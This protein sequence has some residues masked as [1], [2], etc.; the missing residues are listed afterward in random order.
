MP[1]ELETLPGHLVNIGQ[2]LLL[3]AGSKITHIQNIFANYPLDLLFEFR[4]MGVLAGRVWSQEV[5]HHQ[6]IQW[7]WR[8]GSR[9]AYDNGAFSIAR[10]DI[11]EPVFFDRKRVGDGIAVV[12]MIRTV[13]KPVNS[14]PSRTLGGHHHRP[15]RYC[16]GRIA[17]AKRS[18]QPTLADRLQVWQIIKPAIEDQLRCCAVQSNHH[19]SPP[20][21]FRAG[22]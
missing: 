11:P 7:A 10:E 14:K 15:R 18:V 19:H 21:F 1:R 9:N 22:P 2:N 17:R 13:S 5:R 20:R 3:V 12:R 16:N 4:R 6:A 8:V